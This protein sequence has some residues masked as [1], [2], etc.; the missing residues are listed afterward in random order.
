MTDRHR[1][2]GTHTRTDRPQEEK[3]KRKIASG[4][5]PF[6]PSRGDEHWLCQQ[7]HHPQHARTAAAQR[8]AEK[9][10]KKNRIRSDRVR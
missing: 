4:V 7:H 3:T 9:E 1:S 6:D 2:A 5:E 8:Q 10:K